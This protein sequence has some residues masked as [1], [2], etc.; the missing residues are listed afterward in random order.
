MLCTTALDGVI[1]QPTIKD[2]KRLLR[3]LL[4]VDMASYFRKLDGIGHYLPHL[5]TKLGK[6]FGIMRL[7]AWTV[8][9]LNPV[10]GKDHM[11]GCAGYFQPFGDF[12]R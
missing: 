1:G 6:G 3:K 8:P 2:L 9:F 5:V 12:T 11:C 4:I 7:L 10:R